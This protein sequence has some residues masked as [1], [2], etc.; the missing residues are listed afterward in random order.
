M[1]SFIKFPWSTYTNL[2]RHYLFPYKVFVSVSGLSLTVEMSGKLLYLKSKTL[3]LAFKFFVL[4]E[5]FSCISFEIRIPFWFLNCPLHRTYS[6]KILRCIQIWLFEDDLRPIRPG[7][8]GISYRRNGICITAN[9]SN[10]LVHLFFFTL[11]LT[12]ACHQASRK[13]NETMVQGGFFAALPNCHFT[14]VIF[15]TAFLFIFVYISNFK[16]NQY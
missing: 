13:K 15:F 2:Q 16:M 7:W 12:N 1:F 8:H 3:Y 9:S 14:K 5:W 11:G 10:L 4:K 6:F